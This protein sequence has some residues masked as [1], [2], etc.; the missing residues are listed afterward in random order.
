[1]TKIYLNGELVDSDFTHDIPQP[2][3]P[4]TVSSRQMRLALHRTNMLLD[5]I[6][7]VEASTNQEVKIAWEYATEFRRNDPMVV[8]A[9]S[10]L[11]KTDQEMDELFTLAATL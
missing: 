4:T 1:M 9:Q 2:Q 8:W 5:V 7:F 6:T 3:T 11:N 10:A